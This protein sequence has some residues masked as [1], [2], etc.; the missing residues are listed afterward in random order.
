MVGLIDPWSGL[1]VTAA[2]GGA[3]GYTLVAHTAAAGLNAPVT[4]AGIN[5]TGANFLVVAMTFLN[6]PT[7]TDSKG[8][9]WTGLTTKTGGAAK[10]RL[11]YCANP[12]V[13]SGHTFSAADGGVIAAVV[14]VQAWSGANSTPFDVENGATGATISSLASGS[15]TPSVNNSLLVVGL[16][17]DS[18]STS[19][20]INS[21]FT[22]SD[23]TNYAPGNNFGGHMAY[24]VQGTAGSI[25]PTWSWTTNTN[26]AAVIAS[27]KP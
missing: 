16:E 15:V 19:V 26:A 10:T 24:F 11:F 14:S 22:I 21:S 9:T 27:F 4:T 25:N 7:L 18:V 8:N 2:S 6:A 23:S 12:T 17:T 1:L 20:G 3:A 13:G 5:T